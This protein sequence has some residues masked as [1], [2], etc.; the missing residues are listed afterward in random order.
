M[1]LLSYYERCG[2]LG[3]PFHFSL[4]ISYF[5]AHA[6]FSPRYRDLP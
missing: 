1:S 3:S 5:V 4:C 6:I 2:F